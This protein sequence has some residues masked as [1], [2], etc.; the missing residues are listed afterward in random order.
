LEWDIRTVHW[1]APL[2]AGVLFGFA[3]LALHVSANSYIID[4][5]STYAASAIAVF[6]LGFWL[7]MVY[8]SIAPIPYICFH[9]WGEGKSKKAPKAVKGGGEERGKEGEV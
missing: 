9:V 7:A 6:R 2:I 4:F 3:M 8:V 5:Y 1:I